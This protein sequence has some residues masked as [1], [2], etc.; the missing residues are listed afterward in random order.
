MAQSLYTVYKVPTSHLSFARVKISV[1]SYGCASACL[2]IR[3]RSAF[4]TILNVNSG[5]TAPITIRETKIAFGKWRG[6]VIPQ[7]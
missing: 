7:L 2:T 3:M 4:G 1:T 5:T 6:G